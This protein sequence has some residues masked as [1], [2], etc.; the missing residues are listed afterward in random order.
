MTVQNI[1]I[2]QNADVDIVIALLSADPDKEYLVQ[3]FADGKNI[4]NKAT[5]KL[6]GHDDIEIVEGASIDFTVKAMDALKL[7]AIAVNYKLFEIPASDT[8]VLLVGG[9]VAVTALEGTVLPGITLYSKV[10]VRRNVDAADLFQANDYLILCDTDSAGLDND[11]AFALHL[12]DP[13]VMPGKLLLVKRLGSH[14]VDI[15]C[16]ATGQ[17]QTL[18]ADGE[19]LMLISGPVAGH[20]DQF[21][22]HI[23]NTN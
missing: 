12:Y 1:A 8:P 9:S 15:T 22:W 18:N 13:A 21:T 3:F 19:S 20:D 4:L 14:N 7:S 23:F 6:G 16:E 11:E 10:V 2:D 5:N 17:T